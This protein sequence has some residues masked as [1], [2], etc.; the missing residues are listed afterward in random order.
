MPI[1][2]LPQTQLYHMPHGQCCLEVI[3]R[4][5]FMHHLYNSYAMLYLK[6]YSQHI[7]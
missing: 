3:Y 4:E 2:C 6:V 7:T 5:E 1:C